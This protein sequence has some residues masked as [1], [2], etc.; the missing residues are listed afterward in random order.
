M[1]PKMVKQP[2]AKKQ[3]QEQE[4][5]ART[6]LD[7]WLT[8]N[9]TDAQKVKTTITAEDAKRI[10]GWTE[11]EKNHD[12]VDVEHKKISC[13]NNQNNRDV[14]ESAL[15]A[16]AL[17]ILNRNWAYNGETIT[18]GRSGQIIS[19]QRRLVGLVFA[20]QKRTGSQA[21][22]WSAYWEG[23]VAIEAVILYNVDDSQKTSL[24]VDN[25]RPRTV[26]DVF[27]TDPQ[28]ARFEIKKRK[29]VAR[30]LDTTIRILW[31]RTG[32]EGLFHS[33]RNIAELVSFY[34]RHPKILQAVLH[35]YEEDGEDKKISDSRDGWI[36]AG[37]AS[38]LLYLMGVS[39]SEAGAYYAPKANKDGIRERSEKQLDFTNWDKACEFWTLLAQ[40]KQ[41]DKSTK[42]YGLFQAMIKVRRPVPDANDRSSGFIFGE[43]STRERACVIC[44]AWQMFLNGD[45]TSIKALKLRYKEDANPLTG[46][47][48]QG[49][50]DEDPTVGGIDR[51]WKPDKEEAQNHAEE[52][53]GVPPGE[54]TPEQIQAEAAKIREENAQA[55]GLTDTRSLD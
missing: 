55:A 47:W 16:M 10:L 42:G 31:Q 25:T 3:R 6:L 28:I 14:P 37:T 45:E 43:G 13:L 8:K 34:R 11:V 39:T 18:I 33:R 41:L 27:Y 15:H 32:M 22:H 54:P 48:D 29:T 17:D 24:T 2:S 53:N 4:Q 1:P 26:Y 44:K 52:S 50:L 40:A 30:L 9:A 7:K 38:A 36:Q 49:R 35:I 12:F 46:V 51:G 19:G 5:H 23:P 21:P 20:E